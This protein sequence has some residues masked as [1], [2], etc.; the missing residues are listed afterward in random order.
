MYVLN[1]N[2]MFIVCVFWVMGVEPLGCGDCSFMLYGLLM[3]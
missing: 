1:N 3:T 2:S